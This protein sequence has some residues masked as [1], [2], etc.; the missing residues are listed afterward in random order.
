MVRLPALLVAAAVAA[1]VA[2]GGAGPAVAQDDG[3]GGVDYFSEQKKTP[4]T[5]R[6]EGERTRKHKIV[7]LS[8]AGGTLLTAGLA[9]Y[10]HLQSDEASDDVTQL[11]GDHSGL[12]YTQEIDDRRQDAIDNRNLATGMYIVSGAVLVSTV[13]AF[14][15]T[16]PDDEILEYGSS[17]DSQVSTAPYVAP[18]EGGLMVGKTWIY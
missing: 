15:L 13:V 4:L 12:I 1:A 6:M 3:G 8:L 9:V 18:I 5:Y 14:I 16:T 10:F 7:I 2:V 17:G 11:S